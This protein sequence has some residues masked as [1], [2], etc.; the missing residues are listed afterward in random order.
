MKLRNPGPWSFGVF[1]AACALVSVMFAVKAPEA[2]KVAGS[3]IALLGVWLAKSA[4]RTPPKDG[5]R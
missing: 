2:G 3:L 1:A 5:S 4:I